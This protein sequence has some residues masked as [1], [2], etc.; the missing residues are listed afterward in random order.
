MQ[1]E[2]FD[3]TGVTDEREYMP[4]AAEVTGREY[5]EGIARER[6]ADKSVI[7]WSAVYVKVARSGLVVATYVNGERQ[8]S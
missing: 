6:S 4:I 1:Q 7:P 5:A 2:T 8:P 3:V